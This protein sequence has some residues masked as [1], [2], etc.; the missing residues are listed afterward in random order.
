MRSFSVLSPPTKNTEARRTRRVLLLRN[1]QRDR[2]V[3]LGLLRRTTCVLLAD[4]LKL[5]HWQVCIHLVRGAEITQ[6]NEEYLRHEGPTDVITFDYGGSRES[7]GHFA[8]S[9]PVGHRS[10]SREHGN[11]CRIHGEIFIC[12]EQAIL[13][14]RRFR[15]TWQSELMRYVVHGSLHL[16]GFNDTTSVDR[17]RMKRK[18][19]RLLRALSHRLIAEASTRT[20][21]I[22][23]LMSAPQE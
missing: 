3:N 23:W 21:E 4:L 5:E 15:T 18:E 1:R 20:S 7:A 8:P 22:G 11:R 2:P 12:V 17:K 10:S 19:D 14:A 9:K 13:Q 6:I 16:V